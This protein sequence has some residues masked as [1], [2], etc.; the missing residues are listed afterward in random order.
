MRGNDPFARAQALYERSVTPART[1]QMRDLLGEAAAETAALTATT[2]LCQYLNRWDDAGPAEIAIAEAAISQALNYNPEL[3]LAHY[4]QGFLCRTRGEHQAGLAAFER[5]IANAP[6]FARAYAQ[7]GEQLLYLGRFAEAIA[8]VE[9]AIEKSRN[10]KVR[11]YFYWVI[12]RAYFFM[13]QYDDA[14]TWLQ[15]SVRNWPN[16]WYNR[17]YLV[18][19]Y[20]LAGKRGTRG[21]LN[22]FHRHFPGYTLAQVIA[23]EGATPDAHPAVVQGRERFHEGLRLAGIAD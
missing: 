22:T 8:E 15:R 4:A 21:V 12:G 7:K 2:V 13:E 14:I 23:N 6:E 17:A 11:G 19:A 10:S 20:A 9:K 1:L 16:V 3:F 5:T 18:S